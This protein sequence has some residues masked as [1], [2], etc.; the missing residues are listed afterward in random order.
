MTIIKPCMG[1]K[2]HAYQDT[3][4]GPGIRVHNTTKADKD[5]RC[6]VCGKQTPT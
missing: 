1:C 3:K 5:K 6:T 4:Y 2:T